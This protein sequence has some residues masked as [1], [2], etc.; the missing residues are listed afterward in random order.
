MNA[1]HSNASILISRWRIIF[2]V[3]VGFAGQGMICLAQQASSEGRPSEITWRGGWLPE[4]EKRVDEYAAFRGVFTLDRS[5]KL[6]VEIVGAHWFQSWIDEQFLTEGPARFPLGHAEYEVDQ[7]DLNA[8]THVLSALVHNQGISTRLLRGDIIP[9]FLICR[10]FADGKE[11]EVR[12]KVERLGGYKNSGVRISPQFAWIEWVDTKEIPRHW[13]AVGFNDSAWK[14]PAKTEAAEW[15]MQPL[16][17]SPVRHFTVQPKLIAAGLLSGPFEGTEPPNWKKEGDVSWYGRNLHPGNDAVGV[18]RRYDLGKV[19]LGSP[20]F[21]LDLPANSVVEFAYSEALYNRSIVDG[22]S[23][24]TVVVFKEPEV[25]RDP[26]VIPYI[27]LSFPVSRNL[28][29]YV[30]QGG[31]QTFSPLTPKGGR[32]LEVHI[33]ADPEKVKFLNEEFIERS[34]FG[35]PLGRFECSDALLNQ[36]WMLG[37]KTLRGCTEDA[38]IDNPTRERGQWTGDVLLS[39]YIAAAGYND[40]RLFRRGIQQTAYCAR[41]DGMVAGLNPGGPGYLS[42]YAAQWVTS[43]LNYFDLTGD[44]TILEEMYPYAVRDMEA[45]EKA[46]GADGVSQKLGWAFIDWGYVAPDTGSDIGLNLHVLESLR[47]MIRWSLLLGKNPEH[48]SDLA[49]RCEDI[50]HERLDA[51]VRLKKWEKIGY[52]CTV[53][54]YRNGFIP[55]VN[56]ADARQFIKTHIMNCFPNNLQAPRLSDPG[57]GSSQLITPYFSYYAFPILIENGDMDFVLGQYRTC[58]GWALNEGLTTQPEVF[59]LGWSHCHVWASS[60]TAQLSKYVL[61]LVPCFSQGLNHFRFELIPG[62]LDS[63]SG[64]VPFPNGSGV[65]SV[66]WHRMESNRISYELQSS[67][68]VWIHDERFPKPVSVEGERIFMVKYRDQKWVLEN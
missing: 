15:K 1:N 21:L 24:D 62:S 40:V 10:V 60:P 39:M 23:H 41:E 16:S 33:Q 68:P 51:P 67:M 20:R 50:L 7:V 32:Y 47:N 18:W 59:D 4:S 14:V 28:D 30:A 11:V 48:F 8:G 31:V 5:T 52:H 25:T 2:M 53:L 43:I 17:I 22:Y 27:P 6:R 55:Q 44:S 3:C 63:A 19:R 66:H 37:I 54:A 61:G 42:S 57:V 65:V 36:I 38:V 35:D 46:L 13:Q 26:R 34:Y 64:S 45:F 29:H 9:P 56:Q 58:W 12:W 49:R